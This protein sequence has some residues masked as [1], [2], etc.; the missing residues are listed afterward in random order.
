MV[1]KLVADIECTVRAPFRRD[2]IETD[3]AAG[4]FGLN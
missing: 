2:T 3:S 1:W 4:N